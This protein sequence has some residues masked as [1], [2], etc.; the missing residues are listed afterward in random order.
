MLGAAGVLTDPAIKNDIL[1]KM[2]VATGSDG[3]EV[4]FALGELSPSFGNAP[5]LIAYSDTLGQLGN[6]PDGFARLVVPGDLA[7]GRY[8]SNLASLTVFDP[9]AV[10]EPASLALLLAGVAGL[11]T[12]RR[13]A[14]SA[15][16]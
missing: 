2:V 5:I 4:A 3:Y 12:L 6:G 1:R 14:G 7:G 10:P 13:R 16:S 11:V 9:T 8:V 15:A